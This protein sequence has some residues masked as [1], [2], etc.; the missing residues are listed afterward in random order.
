MRDGKD[1]L[2]ARLLR[3]GSEISREEGREAFRE[4]LDRLSIL[5]I[6]ALMRASEAA[7]F[8]PPRLV[9][10]DPLPG[11]HARGRVH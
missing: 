9:V 7:D 11:D 6:D 10:D 5:E 2:G 4:W 3:E 1:E 8:P